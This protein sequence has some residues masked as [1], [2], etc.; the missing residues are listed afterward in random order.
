[1]KGREKCY[2]QTVAKKQQGSQK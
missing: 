1:M 2:A